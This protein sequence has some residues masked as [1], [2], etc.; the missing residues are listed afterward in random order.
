MAGTGGGTE[1][2][3]FPI[4]AAAGLVASLTLMMIKLDEGESAPSKWK[5]AL[6]VI[7][8]FLSAMMVSTVKY[9]TFKKLDLKAT[10]T[11][12]RAMGFALFVGSIF[13]LRDRILYIV[14]P[15]VFTAYLIY[16]F[17]RRRISRKMRREIEEDDENEET[18]GQ[19][20]D[21]P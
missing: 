20:I 4:P 3:G 18:S 16:G 2:L 11:F 12:A 8:V 14:M 17:I 15:I 5:Y 9:P 10:S 6:P 13:I 1:F 19:P 21:S 7:L